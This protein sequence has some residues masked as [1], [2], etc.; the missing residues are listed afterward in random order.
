MPPLN[1]EVGHAQRKMLFLALQRGFCSL[2]RYPNTHEV[3]RLT[4]ET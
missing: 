3:E 4:K 1:G 2:K